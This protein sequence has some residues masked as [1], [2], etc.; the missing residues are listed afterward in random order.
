MHQG[1]H[2]AKVIRSPGRWGISRSLLHRCSGLATIKSHA[3]TFFFLAHHHFRH[4]SFEG[5]FHL[6]TGCR[7]TECLFPPLSHGT[8]DFASCYSMIIQGP[9]CQGS[10]HKGGKK[11]PVLPDLST[12]EA[13]FITQRC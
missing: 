9:M 4:A 10:V 8:S 1:D 6:H 13:V 5:V 11:I 7:R 12:T 2:F 3:T